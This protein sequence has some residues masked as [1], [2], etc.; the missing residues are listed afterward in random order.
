MAP[1]NL[2]YKHNAR[3]LAEEYNYD[4]MLVF[5][6]I[7]SASV[8]FFCNVRLLFASGEHAFDIPMAADVASSTEALERAF[9]DAMSSKIDALGSREGLLKTAIYFHSDVDLTK[10]DMSADN[11]I[12][13]TRLFSTA[14]RNANLTFFERNGIRPG[15][16]MKVTAS[17]S[18]YLQEIQ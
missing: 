18:T 3:Q 9:A 2:N 4:D 16:R 7:A 15:K 5:S 13:A 6:I 1:V 11:V 14:V 8:N 17:S 10:I 12:R